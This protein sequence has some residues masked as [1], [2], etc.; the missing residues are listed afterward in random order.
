[1]SFYTGSLCLFNE[2]ETGDR[3]AVKHRQLIVQEIDPYLSIPYQVRSEL[4]T[5][6]QKK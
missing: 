6:S 4:P 5:M 1:M 3:I 2:R